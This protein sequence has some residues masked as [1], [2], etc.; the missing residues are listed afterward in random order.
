[1]QKQSYLESTIW[2]EKFQ[3]ATEILQS[4]LAF[5]SIRASAQS[6]R[7]K[8]NA[9]WGLCGV[10]GH[11]SARAIVTGRGSQLQDANKILCSI[12]ACGVSG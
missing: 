10:A 3:A 4:N 8:V 12:P 11:S 9:K 2:A 1:M 6:R 7:E 5:S